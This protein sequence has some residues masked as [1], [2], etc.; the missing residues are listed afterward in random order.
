MFEFEIQLAERYGWHPDEIA[1]LDP[2]YVVELRAWLLAK[3]YHD[4]AK[5]RESAKARAKTDE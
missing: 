4:R 2:D 5:E 1:R 3:S